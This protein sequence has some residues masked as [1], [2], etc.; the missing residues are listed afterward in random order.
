MK[1]TLI[2]FSVLLAVICCTLAYAVTEHNSLVF[3]EKAKSLTTKESKSS[4]VD[5]GKTSVANKPQ[6][7]A[8]IDQ[9]SI[10]RATS[11]VADLSEKKNSKA[12]SSRQGNVEEVVVDLW[13]T[14][15]QIIPL[16]DGG[17]FD[18][19]TNTLSFPGSSDAS[20][21]IFT[22]AIANEEYGWYAV[23]RGQTYN[24]TGTLTS[25]SI[26]TI[27]PCIIYDNDGSLYIANESTVNLSEAN[28]Y[29]ADF[30]VS[31]SGIQEGCAIMVAFVIENSSSDR[32][33]TSTNNQFYYT[34]E[35][36]IAQEWSTENGLPGLGLNGFNYG[37]YTVTCADGLTTLGL[38]NNK[39]GLYVTGIN[40]TANAVILPTNITIGEDIKQIDG[41][42][43][44]DQIDWSGAPNLTILDISAASRLY[45]SFGNS[46]ITDL[47]ISADC[48]F[49]NTLSGVSEIYL[50]IPYGA[51][52]SDYANY[53]FKRVLVGDEQPHYPVSSYSNW[54][55]E[56]ENEGDFFGISLIDGY[57]CL[58]EIFTANDSI[59]LP[60]KTP[61]KYGTYYIRCLGADDN[62]GYGE[63][64]RNA[65]AL[66]SITIPDSY[67]H[68][69]VAWSYN[70]FRELHMQGDVLNSMH[71]LDDGG[72]TVFVGSSKYFDNYEEDSNWN[73]AR[74]IP[75]G[76]DFEYLTVNVGR[77]G[78]F[79]QTYI[80]LTDANWNLYR[81]IKVTGTLNETDLQ[82]I[83]NVTKLRILDLSE[84]EFN[85]L[86]S[87]FLR[88]KASII[89]VLLPENITT[90]S[91]SAF[92]QCSML[93][94][95]IAPGIKII[96]SHAFYQCFNLK[97]FDISKVEII[98]YSG[99]SRCSQFNPT[100]LS[101][102]KQIGNYAFDYTAIQEAI[103]PE[104]VSS[105]STETFNH[106]AQLQ[107]VVLPTSV[108]EIGD[109]AFAY[110][111][112]LTSI[113][114]PEGITSTG[115]GAFENCSSLPEITLPST[116]EYINYDTFRGCSSLLSVKCKAIVPPAGNGEFTSGMDLNHCSLF[117][118]PFAIDAYRAAQYW[119]NFYIMKPLNEPVKNIY[120]NRPM[121]FDLLSEDN[122]VLQENPNMT[123]DYASSSDKVGQLSA[124]GDGTLSAGVFKILHSFSGRANGRNSDYRTTLINDAENMR[125]DSVLCSINFE[126][127]RWHFISFQYDVHMEDI[128]G[129]NNTDFV[130]RQYNG[131]NRAS[132]DGKT[133]NWEIVPSDGIMKAGKGYIVQAANNSKNETGNTNQAIVRFPSRNTVTKN[134]LFTSNNVIVPLEEYPS[135][136]AHNRSWNLV[137]NPYPCYYDMHY[138]MDD[139]STPIILWRGTNYQA[140]SPIDDDIILRPNES[141]FVQRPLDADQMVFGVEGRMHYRDAYNN[142]YLNPGAFKKPYYATNQSERAVFNF[143]VEGCG[144][145]DRARI[146]LNE[147]ALM[148]YEINRDAS[149]FFS[150]SP[151]GAEIY[152]DGNIKYDICERPFAEGIAALGTR[153]GTEGEYTISLS[154]KN[155]EEWIVMLTDTHTGV[156]T[157]LTENSY[158][159]DAEPGEYNGRF[160]VT[161][162]GSGQSAIDEINVSDGDN[163]V[164]IVDTA[165]IYVFNG[166]LDDFKAN[167]PAGIYIVVSADKNYKIVVK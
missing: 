59:V 161:F 45:A 87:Y 27:Y 65:S 92:R 61:G 74:I 160:I 21:Q 72:Y 67:T 37:T 39:F 140:Y 56:G 150:E 119:S 32:I 121:T 84:A 132:G 138:L 128:F 164:R 52:R 154:G 123:L 18:A 142:S 3:F 5:V 9:E 141:F 6:R 25:D 38:F 68:A 63:L 48:D 88:D 99:F 145:D 156:T 111:S 60:A 19:S 20:N 13:N 4:A 78:E 11:R 98:N 33:I 126:K 112:H 90:I 55:I 94:R 127:N 133:S 73:R 166:K 23:K 163:I 162:R 106:C 105:I 2:A 135:E 41:F 69:N 49:Y 79:A 10:F 43:Y 109:R 113:I 57:Y 66:K 62:L 80:E 54:V 157:N 110:C 147:D 167:A 7:G 28:S 40:T 71:Y 151:E 35:T 102:V 153:I 53:G 36:V 70:P 1:K 85:D 77:K 148:D 115:Y 46:A 15:T 158:T 50:H 104:G 16:N 101:S 152:V 137:G 44:G 47:Y 26:A 108:R 122:A 125:A 17:A 89:E 129:M 165:G 95:V 134:N 8:R 143:N 22:D 159:F 114:L 14:A 58:S 100:D 96:G 64:C 76:W 131:N 42:G 97:E 91:E 120:I 130:I 118:A 75:E 103:I 124:T 117:I 30:N 34:Y 139:F 81:N 93:K 29:T 155:M 107:S 82:N 149:K 144:T 31:A 146:V 12:H 116:L 136:F 51:R 83:K 24:F 86:P